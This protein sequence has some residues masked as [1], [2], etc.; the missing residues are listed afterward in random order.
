MKGSGIVLDKRSRRD[1]V[2]AVEGVSACSGG[3]QLVIL[4]DHFDSGTMPLLH[5]MSAPA[6]ARLP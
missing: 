5:R 1:I 2:V 3:K 4:T 6:S